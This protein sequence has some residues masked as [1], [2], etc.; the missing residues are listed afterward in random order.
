MT[1]WR[2][3]IAAVAFIVVWMVGK[4]LIKRSKEKRG[5]STTPTSDDV[6][7]WYSNAQDRLG[8]MDDAVRVEREKEWDGLER[9]EQITVSDQFM[10]RRFGDRMTDSYTNDEKLTRVADLLDQES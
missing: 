5:E 1:N 8:A 7:R 4:Y 6:E 3:F 9:L 2:I 10:R